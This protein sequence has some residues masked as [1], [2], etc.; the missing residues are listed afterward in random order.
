MEYIKNRDLKSVNI[1]N[2]KDNNSQVPRYGIY[3]DID[4]QTAKS[5]R[6]KFTPPSLPVVVNSTFE[7]GEP[8]SVVIDHDVYS[9]AKEIIITDNNPDGTINQIVKIPSKNHQND[10]TTQIITPPSI[11]N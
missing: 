1:Y 5:N 9:Q 7:S 4:I 6:D 11:G 2:K 10:E 8:Y 3:A